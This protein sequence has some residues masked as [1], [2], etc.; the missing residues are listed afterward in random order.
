MTSYLC[1]ITLRLVQYVYF[2]FVTEKHLYR[3]QKSFAELM[4]IFTIIAL[5]RVFPDSTN[6]PAV[7]ASTGEEAVASHRASSDVGGSMMQ[8]SIA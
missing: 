5:T 2:F 3:F 4:R 6:D 8:A 1:G 7:A